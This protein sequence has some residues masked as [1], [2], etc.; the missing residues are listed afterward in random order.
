MTEE[1][2]SLIIPTILIYLTLDTDTGY[3]RVPLKSNRTHTTRLMEVYSTLCT[4]TTRSLGTGAGVDTVLLDTGLIQGT[5]I[6][7]PTFG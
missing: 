1:L 7:H 2:T 4:P 3:K 5:V 6:I